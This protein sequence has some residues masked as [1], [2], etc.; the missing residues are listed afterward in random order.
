ME[1]SRRDLILRSLQDGRKQWCDLEREL[2]KS[3]KMG[4]ATLSN[5][6]KDLER[7]GTVRRALD[8]SHRPPR[9]WYSLKVSNSDREHI[10]K[11]LRQIK[12]STVSSYERLPDG[13]EVWRA[14]SAPSGTKLE[15][16]SQELAESVGKPWGLIE[17]AAYAV[18]KELN[19]RI[20]V[21]ANG[22]T[23]FSRKPF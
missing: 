7:E 18:G 11:I 5:H 9:S 10:L 16:T 1:T 8:N 2:V 19:L 22:E 17:E 14:E 3:G 23:Y 12:P 21:R 13:T 6:L 15:V 20:R 4:S